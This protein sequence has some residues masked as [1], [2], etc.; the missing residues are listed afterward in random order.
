M[1]KPV[2]LSFIAAVALSVLS[3]LSGSAQDIHFSQFFETPLLRNPALS[4]IFTGDVRVQSVYRSQWK[5]VTDPY[6]TTSLNGEYKLPLGKREDFITIAGEILYDKAGSIS[7]TSTYILPAVNYHK[8]LSEERN[9]YLSLGFMGG[10]VQ[11]KFDRSKITTNSQ[12]DGN[13]YNSSLFDGENISSSSYSYFDGSAGLSLSSQIGDNQDNNLFVGVAYHHFNKPG[14]LSFY[15]NANN[16]MTPKWVFSGGLKMSTSDYS[17]VTFHG[18]FVKQGGYTETIGGMVYSL[19]LGDVENS[20]YTIHGG[21]LYRLKDAIIPYAKIDM[22]CISVSF[23]Y[24]ANVSQL[25]SASYGR[26]GFEMGLSYIKFLDRNNST[27]NAVRCPK[28]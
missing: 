22:N 3:V 17:Y 10:L 16:E 1:K 28:F 8:S 24:D 6:Q 9:M 26:G 2:S 11:R 27:K 20:K 18:D 21:A 25:K 12:F 13:A 19:K 4:G 5:S 15:T 7:L 23:T 14:N